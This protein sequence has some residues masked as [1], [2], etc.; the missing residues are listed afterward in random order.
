MTEEE[1][2]AAGYFHARSTRSGP[3]HFTTDGIKTA[4]G[5]GL[6]LVHLAEKNDLGTVRHHDQCS[7]CQ[8]VIG[9]V[10]TEE[11]KA[12][13]EAQGAGIFGVLWLCAKKED[14]R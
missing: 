8:S 7:D 11:D 2:K 6:S 1:I 3:W 13:V 10:L 4:C 14:F 12:E 9:L 5:R